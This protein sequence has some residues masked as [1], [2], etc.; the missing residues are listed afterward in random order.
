MA[1]WFML[2]DK[3]ERSSPAS[4]KKRSPMAKQTPPQKHIIDEEIT[5][6][7]WDWLLERHEQGTFNKDKSPEQM[8]QT[9]PP[10]QDQVAD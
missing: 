4:L 1:N 10:K 2:K 5:D 3:A 8:I 9:E 7:P 6:W